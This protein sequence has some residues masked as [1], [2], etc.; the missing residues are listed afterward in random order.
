MTYETFK[1]AIL[2]NRFFLKDGMFSK[3]AAILMAAWTFVLFKFLF[4]TCI[5]TFTIPVVS[6]YI[7]WPIIF[8]WA[9]AGA[10]TTSASALY[11]AVNNLRKDVNRTDVPPSQAAMTKIDVN[12][13]EAEINQAKG[14]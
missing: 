11:F 1:N 7:Y 4:A 12:I 6:V 2:E 3:T 13:K 10:I 5:I 8:N 14:S 9:D